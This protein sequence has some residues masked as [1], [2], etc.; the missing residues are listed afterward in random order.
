MKN[1]FFSLFFYFSPILFASLSFLYFYK[2]DIQK[3][4]AISLSEKEISIK[5][6]QIQDEIPESEISS[7]AE[8]LFGL[9]ITPSNSH[10]ST[11]KKQTTLPATLIGTFKSDADGESRAIIA[12]ADSDPQIYKTGSKISRS[13][14]VK[15]IS[16]ETILISNKGQLEV[17]SLPPFDLNKKSY[18]ENIKLAQRTAPKTENEPKETPHR[19]ILDQLNLRP[20]SENT[21]SGYEVTKNSSQLINQYKLKPGDIIVSANG[22]PLGTAEDDNLALKSFEKLKRATITI[23]RGDTQIS[24]EYPPI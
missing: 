1:K 2:M 5:K 14:F 6:S 13:A 12:L 15:S 4:E 24:V 3:P 21:A 19:K 16:K 18:S 22:F 9:P 10:P 17:L 23:S 8:M 11:V 7:M 20:V